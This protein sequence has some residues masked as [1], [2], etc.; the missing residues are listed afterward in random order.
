MCS[1]QNKK[2]MRWRHFHNGLLFLLLLPL[3]G[4][5]N[6]DRIYLSIFT[7]NGTL[8]KKA[9]NIFVET[10]SGI[11]LAERKTRM[12]IHFRKI[13]YIGYKLEICPFL[14]NSIHLLKNYCLSCFPS[15]LILCRQQNISR[16][17]VQLFWSR[18]S[19]QQNYNSLFFSTC[20]IKIGYWMWIPYALKHFR[21]FVT[22]HTKWPD[23]LE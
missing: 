20:Q 11:Q 1:V 10:K 4:D 8:R 13:Y 12:R 5:L 9:R 14:L 17:S 21:K 6:A 15:Q 16:F 7:T 3:I 18:I 2:A 23:E 22:E 19:S